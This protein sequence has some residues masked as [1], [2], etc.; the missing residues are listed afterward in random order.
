MGLCRCASTLLHLHQQQVI[1]VLLSP[2]QPAFSSWR[3]FYFHQPPACPALCTSCRSRDP[4]SMKRSIKPQGSITH[5]QPH[6]SPDTCSLYAYVSEQF[7]LTTNHLN[8]D[9]VKEPL[10]WQ[11][12]LPQRKNRRSSS[13]PSA[14]RC[15]EPIPSSQSAVGRWRHRHPL[16]ILQ[17][18]SNSSLNVGHFNCRSFI[19]LLE[20]HDFLLNFTMDIMS[21][22]RWRNGIQTSLRVWQTQRN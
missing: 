9:S 16:K 14:A 6:L 11:H 10:P 22:K 12:N 5:K 21:T 3:H 17:M 4:W 19:T 2:D 20:E 13:W 7:Y 1:Q 18:H 15:D 8:W